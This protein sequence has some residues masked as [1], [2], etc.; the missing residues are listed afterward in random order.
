VTVCVVLEMLALGLGTCWNVEAVDLAIG[1]RGFRDLVSLQYPIS[2]KKV[3]AKLSSR[4]LVRLIQQI[5]GVTE[6]QEQQ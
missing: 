5:Q 1:Y 2:S 3:K 6:G 4:L